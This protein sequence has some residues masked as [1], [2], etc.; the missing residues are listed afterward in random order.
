MFCAESIELTYS[1]ECAT[2][3]GTLGPAVYHRNLAVS[4]FTGRSGA[5]I[6]SHLVLKNDFKSHGELEFKYEA[7][8]IR[9]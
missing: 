3:S 1:E 2:G 7:S 4:V 9:R 5:Y 6:I 8:W